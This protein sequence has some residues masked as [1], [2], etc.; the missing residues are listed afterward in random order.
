MNFKEEELNSNSAFYRVYNIFQSIDT[1]KRFKRDL[2]N[3]ETAAEKEHQLK[4]I[5][6]PKLAAPLRKTSRDGGEPSKDRDSV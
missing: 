2:F 1:T 6:C 5:P 4:R 3:Q